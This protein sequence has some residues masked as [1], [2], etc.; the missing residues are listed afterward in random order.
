MAIGYLYEFVNISAIGI[1][2]DSKQ[3]KKHTKTILINLF[4]R[5]EGGNIIH[6]ANMKK[7]DEFYIIGKSFAQLDIELIETRNAPIHLLK[8]YKGEISQVE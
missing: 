6:L 1:S 5:K 3:L 2:K 7:D 8:Y 4:G